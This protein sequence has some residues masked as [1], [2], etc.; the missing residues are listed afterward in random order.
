MMAKK[1]ARKHVP[2]RTCVVCRQKMD[3]R[4]LTRIV[5][6]PD[7][8]VVVDPSGKQPGRGAYL[9]D[10]VTCWKEA[11]TGSVLDR[12][13]RTTVAPEDKEALA[14][15]RPRAEDVDAV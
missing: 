10:Q 6:L 1:R 3:K 4:R 7:G 5:R 14:A 8:H 9:C 12:A 15:Q 11:V 2:Q 13:L